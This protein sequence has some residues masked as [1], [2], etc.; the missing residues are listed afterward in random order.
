MP[1]C[2]TRT[3]K[4]PRHARY[5]LEKAPAEDLRTEKLQKKEGRETVLDE[6]KQVIG[7]PAKRTA[8]N[9]RNP[10]Q[11]EISSCEIRLP[12][13]DIASMYRDNPFH[14]FEHASHVTLSVNKLTVLVMKAQTIDYQ[15]LKYNQDMED[16][17]HDATYGITSDP[18]IP[19]ACALSALIHDVDLSGVPNAQLVKEEAKL[20]SLYL[21]KSVAEQ[22]S[23]DVAWEL[24]MEPI[25]IESSEN[26][27]IPMKKS[28][29]DSA[30]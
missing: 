8:G 15:E 5:N 18:I 10:D 20:V 4:N 17:S 6:M 26:A 9:K 24:F 22:D 13:F 28:W 14:S 21:N 16:D 11:V 25:I 19:F 23:V 1:T 3:E 29:N 12:P 7:L 2:S 30:S 27:S